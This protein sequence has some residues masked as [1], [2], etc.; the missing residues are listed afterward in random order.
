MR[1]GIAAV[2]AATAM[3]IAP[4]AAAASPVASPAASLS[5]AKSVRAAAPAKKGESLSRE[6]SRFL[7][8]GVVVAAIVAGIFVAADQIGSD[9]PDSN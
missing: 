2:A 8:G 7:I 4:V 3:M 5:V 9:D 6:S 1:T